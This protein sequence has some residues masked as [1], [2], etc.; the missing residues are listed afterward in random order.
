MIVSC[1]HRFI[2]N[3]EESAN[4]SEDLFWPIFWRTKPLRIKFIEGI[5]KQAS[6]LVNM[7]PLAIV[8]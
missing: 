5:F 7:L 4:D 6:Q 3:G 1:W 2:K 8:L